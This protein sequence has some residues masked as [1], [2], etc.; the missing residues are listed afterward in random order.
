MGHQ[1][2][3][4]LPSHSVV[5]I[6][7]PLKDDRL[8]WPTRGSNPRPSDRES[9]TQSPEPPGQAARELRLNK[10]IIMNIYMISYKLFKYIIGYRL[11][12]AALT[13]KL[14]CWV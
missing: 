1:I 11:K 10:I 13:F 8:S 7:R 9:T 6:Y 12:I 2:K 4:A 5:L 14:L 3:G